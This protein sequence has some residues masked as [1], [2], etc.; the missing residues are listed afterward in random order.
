M[1][2]F[3][4]AFAVSSVVLL[5][6]LAVSPLKDFFREWK[7]YQLRYDDV[8]SQLPQRINPAEIGIKQIWAQKL[9]RVDRCTTCHL[10][11]DEKALEN[12]EQ[13]FRTHPRIY[14]KVED[15]GCT[16][17]HE[18]QGS[19]TTVAEAHGDIEFW[20]RPIVPPG[21]M[22][23]SCGKCHKE[24]EVPEAPILTLGR[25]LIRESNC[26][27]CHKI[28]KYPR[29]WVPSLDGI[30][31]K[32]N[33][34]WLFNWLKNPKGY[35]ANAKMPNFLLTDDEANNLTDFLLTYKSFSND[36]QL[37]SLPTL[38]TSVTG[39]QRDKLVELGSTRFREA[40]CISCHPINGRGGYVATDLVKVASKTNVQ[41]IYNYIK[42]P[43]RLQPGVQMPRFGF[44]QT[45]L[46]AVTAY[47]ESEFVDYDM[48]ELPPHTPDPGYYEKG[49]AVLKKY[50]CTGCHTLG[51]M[52]KAE[53]MGPELTVVGSKSKYEIDFG[54]AEVEHS[55]PSYLYAKLKHPRVFSAAMKMPEYEFSDNEAQAITVALLGNTNENIPEQL[56]IPPTP[57]GTFDPQGA[58][59]RLADT[60]ACFGCHT[61]FGRGR[62]VA[63]NLSIEASQAQRKWIE[64]YFKIPYSLRP[65]LT[66]RMPNLFLSDLEIKTIVD[67]MEAVFAADSIEREI[68]IDAATVAQGKLLYY[69]TYGCQGCHQINLK[70]GFVGPALDKVGSRLK[71]GWIYHWLKNPQSFKPGTIEPNNNLN[72]TEAR[73]MTAFL[74]SL[75]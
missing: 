2:K 11:L 35:F 60:L 7:R 24:H 74:M 47:I 66:E 45:D 6:V 37:D 67:Y 43:K 40:R 73:A 25:K 20:D 19:A 13:P 53:A 49:L 71:P 18:G 64:G 41:W 30:G 21:F 29:Q 8:I 63:T 65:I 50:N 54:K 26:T 39:A 58:F 36:V 31:T 33:R 70:G 48:K 62:L 10:G 5:I 55:L 27:G 44:T 16:V 22:E 15:F 4:V 42:N 59:G 23:A 75:Q 38:V 1:N 72:E 9:D 17:C 61:M 34:A 51:D 56:K 52:K 28:G 3:R 57:S 12:A 14:H 32:V 68:S 69:G 46:A